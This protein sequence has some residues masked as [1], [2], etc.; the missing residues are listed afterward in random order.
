MMRLFLITI[1]VTQ[2]GC[3]ELTGFVIGT[4]SNVT[5]DLITEYIENEKKKDAENSPQETKETNET[6]S[7][8]G[9]N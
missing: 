6:N 1:M 2:L 4:A 7:E 9:D 5:G 8:A 3:A